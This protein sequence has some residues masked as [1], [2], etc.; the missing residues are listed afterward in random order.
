MTDILSSLPPELL[1]DI[2][3]STIP[4][5]FHSTT[6]AER[7]RTLRSFSL[8]SRQFRAIAQP[9]LSDIVF[10]ASNS[11]LE[12]LAKTKNGLSEPKE[13]HLTDGRDCHSIL[14]QLER[15]KGIKS[16]GIT[17]S[18]TGQPQIDLRSLAQLAGLVNL[19]V[20][21]SGFNCT[22]SS[23][24]TRLHSLSVDSGALVAIMKS[25][26]S[27]EVLPS[28]RALGLNTF[29]ESHARELV[30]TGLSRLLPQ[31]D[32][33]CVPHR[34]YGMLRSGIFAGYSSRIL[35][36]VP[37]MYLDKA[38]AAQSLYLELHLRITKIGKYIARIMLP[39]SSASSFS[40]R[41]ANLSCRYRTGDG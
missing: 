8:V 2:I 12:L 28:L 7:Q 20:S 23:P 14:E 31:L 5:T 36:D 13:L 10:I 11:Q 33:I 9:L 34:A 1:R 40:P 3:E 22:V 25:L 30:Q 35:V 17:R 19:Q 21:G 27:P 37:N 24:F 29:S 4:S 6:Y 26:L 38:D 32:A 18:R 15:W 41:D 39:R 16:L